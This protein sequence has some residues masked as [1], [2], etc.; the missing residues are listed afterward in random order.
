MKHIVWLA[1]ALLALGLVWMFGRERFSPEFIDHTQDA[2]TAAREDSSYSQQTNHM[3]FAP[4]DL[5]GASGMETPF[6]VNQ[7]KAHL[8]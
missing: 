5:S 8:D 4:Y 6:Q 3:N 2:K 7:Y 1:V